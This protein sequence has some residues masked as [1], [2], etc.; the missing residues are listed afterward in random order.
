MKILVVDNDSQLLEK[1]AVGVR[2]QWEDALVIAAEDAEAALRALRHQHPDL[3][4]LS[5]DLPR[6]Q[7][8]SLLQDIRELSD[9]RIVAVS[10]RGEE[11]LQVAALEAGA[12]AYMVRPFDHAALIA[13]VKALLRRTRQFS[14]ARRAPDLAFGDLAMDFHLR[15]VTLGGE[16]VKLTPVEYRL[17]Y[18]LMRNAGRVMPHQELLHRVWTHRPGATTD[19]LKVFISRLRAK[20]ERGQGLRFIETERGLGYRFVGDRRDAAHPCPDQP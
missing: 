9:V 3:V 10:S 1:M 14:P 15:R 13:R 12:D 20:I 6:G 2:L 11:V 5:M 16:L 8:L 18:H 4:I 17:L 19:H 7:S